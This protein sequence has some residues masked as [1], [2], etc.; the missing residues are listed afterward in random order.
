MAMIPVKPDVIVNVKDIEGVQLGIA[1]V[2][3]YLV[4][5]KLV[6]LDRRVGRYWTYPLRQID[7][8][9][10]AESLWLLRQDAVYGKL[11]WHCSECGKRVKL[12]EATF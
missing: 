2:D 7:F 3:C 4:K 9:T 10:N 8:P 6:L 11:D 12:P 1:R 5:E